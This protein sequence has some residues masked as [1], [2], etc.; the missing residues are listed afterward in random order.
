MPHLEFELLDE[1]VVRV[2]LQRLLAAH[3]ALLVG[4]A[5]RLRHKPGRH[6]SLHSVARRLPRDFSTGYDL[7]QKAG[8]QVRECSSRRRSVARIDAQQAQKQ[9]PG[10]SSEL[11]CLPRMRTCAFMMRS[12][13]AD[14]PCLEVTTTTGV[15]A[16]RLDTLTPITSLPS[17]SFHHLVRSLNSSCGGRPNTVQFPVDNAVQ[18]VDLEYCNRA[19]A[20]L[21]CDM[22]A[23]CKVLLERLLADLGL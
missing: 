2:N 21:L 9:D 4:V 19:F 5:H 6:Y 20:Q 7:G 11:K 22:S 8:P 12:M 18:P 14:Q 1:R 10:R 16:R 23:V 15:L 3:V 13:L 17:C